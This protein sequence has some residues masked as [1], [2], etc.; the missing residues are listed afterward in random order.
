MPV[1]LLKLEPLEVKNN[2]RANVCSRIDEV[3]AFCPVCKTL[4]T[5][6]LSNGQLT[7]T[8]KFIQNDGHIYHDCG[9]IQPC[10]LYCLY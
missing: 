2:I 6:Y 3:A 9:S 4:E 8:R 5:L 10:Q 7:L 1:G